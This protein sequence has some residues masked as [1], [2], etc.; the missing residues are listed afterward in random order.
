MDECEL[1]NKAK[2]V[3]LPM[4]TITV[5]YGSEIY[6]F[7]IDLVQEVQI[8]V[9]NG[10]RR[11]IRSRSLYSNEPLVGAEGTNSILTASK[12]EYLISHVLSLAEKG[13]SG[14]DDECIVCMEA[15]TAQKPSQ[16]LPQCGT[17]YYHEAC[18]TAQL[19][20]NGKCAVCGKH[21]VV[22]EG[23]QPKNGL[24]TVRTHA[25]GT[26]HTGL[27]GFPPSVGTIVITYSFPSGVQGVEHPSP[28]VR[29]GGTNRYAYLP[30]TRE[31]REVLELL[32]RAFDQRLVFTVGRSLTNGTDNVVIW[33]G[34]HHKVHSSIL[35]ILNYGL[36]TERQYIIIVYI[37]LLILIVTSR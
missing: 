21:Y 19:R 30:D 34:I 35:N 4:I 1:I 37:I 26:G 16:R 15:F 31:G 36:S 28:G 13:G 33:N 10:Y 2:A 7:N 32:R 22:L 17:H 5:G 11:R 24:M 27:E 25:P 29:Y 9:R 23:N 14:E 20:I 6:S 3:G 18:I 8:S 12:R